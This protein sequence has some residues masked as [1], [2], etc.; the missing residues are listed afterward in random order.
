METV[1]RLHDCG[2]ERF[3]TLDDGLR[4]SPAPEETQVIPVRWGFELKRSCPKQVAALQVM[5]ALVAENSVS[6]I[7]RVVF[8]KVR[9]NECI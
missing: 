4:Y 2:P 6:S 8:G 7:I 5:D 9:Y 3:S 1:Q